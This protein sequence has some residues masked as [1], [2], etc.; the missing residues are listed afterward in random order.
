MG[1]AADCKNVCTWTELAAQIAECRSNQYGSKDKARR[2]PSNPDLARGDLGVG[3]VHNRWNLADN[4]GRQQFADVLGIVQA[5]VQELE[6]SGDQQAQTHTDAESHGAE[7]E[8]VGKYRS[9]RIA[10]RIDDA[11]PFALLQDLHAGGHL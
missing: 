3:G 8:A 10:R 5:V 2:R 9:L 1:S 11:K 6:G 4:F 7:L